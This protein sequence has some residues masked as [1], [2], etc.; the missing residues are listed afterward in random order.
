V[1]NRP[2]IVECWIFRVPDGAR[3]PEYL[4]IRRAPGRIYAGLWQPVTGRLEPGER[5]THA[6]L[7]E[8]AE[9]VGFGL[10]DIEAFYDLD[11]VSSFYD[12]GL[13]AIVSSVI[14][15][16][17]VRAS[18]SPRLSAEHDGAEWAGSAEAVR[19]S[20]WPSYR[21]TIARIEAILGD[22]VRAH[23]ANLDLEGRRLAR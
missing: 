15:A 18:A 23:Y 17:R 9:E 1:S 14:F 2:D 13:D 4:L 6:A 3:A 20:I 5:V 19:R 10:A 11:Q 7:R 22:P 8:V 12:A 21:E 16:M